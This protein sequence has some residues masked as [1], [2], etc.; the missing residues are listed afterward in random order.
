[1]KDEN[2]FSEDKILT[3]LATIIDEEIQQE[4]L[5]HEN[6]SVEIPEALDNKLLNMARTVDLERKA[7]QKKKRIQHFQH[8]VACI[9]I[10]VISTGVISMSVSEAFRKRVFNLFSN[11]HTGSITLLSE[12]EQ[13]KIGTWGDYW[14]PE[15]LPERVTLIAAEEGDHFL[16]FRD[17]E[18]SVEVRIYEM[19]PNA[20]ISIDSDTTKKIAFTIGHY[21]GYL[22]EMKKTDQ[23]YAVWLTDSTM[24]RAEFKGMEHEEIMKVINNMKYIES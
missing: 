8:L 9:L 19:D 14:Y 20:A 13:Q 23:F 24:I 22:F 10:C 12:D 7:K 16:L 17:N 6:S 5:E 4:I 21:D 18:E 1:M 15:Y 3:E 2:V 11:G